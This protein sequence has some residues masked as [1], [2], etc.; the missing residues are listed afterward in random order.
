[1]VILYFIGQNCAT[2]CFLNNPWGGVERGV[3][4]VGLD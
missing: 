4:P 3:A 1:M 2:W